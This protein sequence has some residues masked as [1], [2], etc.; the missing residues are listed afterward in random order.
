MQT[1]N[2]VQNMEEQIVD[3]I[4]G[5]RTDNR[6]ENLRWATPL[7]NMSFKKENQ[8]EI[9]KNIQKAIQKFGYDEFNQILVNLIN[10]N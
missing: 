2:P 5:I 3:H 8:Y 1:F 10:E 6:L 9:Q 7:E 4:N